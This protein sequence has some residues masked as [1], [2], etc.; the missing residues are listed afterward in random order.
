MCLVWVIE[1]NVVF[2]DIWCI[3]IVRGVIQCYY[4]G[5]IGDFMFWNQQFIF[6]V[7]QFCNSDCFCFMINI[8]DG[9]QLELEIMIVCMG[10]IV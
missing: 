5:V 10:Q 6:F 8:N 7:V 9:I 1:E 2:F 3:E 4:Q